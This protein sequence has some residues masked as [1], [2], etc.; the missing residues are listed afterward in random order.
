MAL[1]EA[2]IEQAMQDTVGTPQKVRT[3][4]GEVQARSAMDLIALA[5]YALALKAR[6][7]PGKGIMYTRLLPGSAVGTALFLA[8]A[9]YGPIYVL[10]PHPL[11]WLYAHSV[12]RI[13]IQLWPAAIFATLLPLARA[14][15]Q[16]PP[17][18]PSAKWP[19]ER[20]QPAP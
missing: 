8:C 5:N 12:E 9:A 14:A 2:A 10:Q 17:E 20:A 1:D 7:Q 13:F 11:P 19:M 3:D 15:G 16:P 6:T 4:G 18:P